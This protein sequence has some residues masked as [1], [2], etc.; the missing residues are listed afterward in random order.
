MLHAIYK[1]PMI[2][3]AICPKEQPILVLWLIVYKSP[4]VCITRNVLHSIAIFAIVLKVSFIE[5]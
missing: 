5:A 2:D 3:I 4:N 1:R